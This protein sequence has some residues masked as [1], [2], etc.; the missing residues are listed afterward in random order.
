MSENKDESVVNGDK[1]YI[2]LQDYERLEKDGLYLLI[3]R[4]D[5][6]WVRTNAMG[7]K[8]LE[9]LRSPRRFEEVCDILSR[10]YSI[11]AHLIREAIEPFFKGALEIGFV[12]EVGESGEEALFLPLSRTDDWLE[13]LPIMTIWLH[14]TNACNLKCGY[15]SLESD[16][17]ADRARDLTV[18]EIA[19]LYDRLPAGPRYKTVISG[20]E[21]FVRKDILE[22]LKA[23]KE[24]GLT[25]LTTN[26]IVPERGVLEE[27]LDYLDE[28]QVSVDGPDASVHDLL[29]GK[30]SFDKT[31]STLNVIKESGFKDFWIATTATRHNVDHLKEMVRFAYSL[32]AKGLYIGRLMPCGR[33]REFEAMAPS[34]EEI[35]EALEKV[36]FAYAMLMDFHKNRKGFDFA[37]TVARD[38]ITRTVFGQKFHTCGLG[39][40]GVI[41]VAHSGNVYPCSLLHVEELKLGNVREEPFHA[42]LERSRL[43]YRQ[44]TVDASPQCMDCS[45][46]YMCGGGCPALAYHLHGDMERQNTECERNYN[47]IIQWCWKVTPKF[48]RP[49]YVR[50]DVFSP[51]PKGEG[52]EGDGGDPRNNAPDTAR[53]RE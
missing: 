35:D 15:C 12:R 53:S 43:T 2:A 11:P 33:G 44:R 29:R 51:G 31:L 23:S 38:K 48:F 3:S 47:N 46:R 32:E 10:E 25:Y 40:C 45:V 17:K 7:L 13:N 19:G 1:A 14:V 27:S 50:D 6:S 37:L 41:S 16:P 20:G 8:L 30:G 4:L 34:D 39:G 21:P 42:I 49:S 28:I 24:H 36:W 5:S 18:E 52:G 26:G 9:L 22:I